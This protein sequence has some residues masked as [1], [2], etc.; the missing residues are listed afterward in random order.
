M[1]RRV[2]DGRTWGLGTDAEVAWVASGT[3][4]GQTSTAAIPPVFEAVNRGAGS[5]SKPC[6]A[7]ADRIMPIRTTG[8]V[9]EPDREDVRRGLRVAGRGFAA[10]VPDSSS[11][12]VRGGGFAAAQRHYRPERELRLYAVIAAILGRWRAAILPGRIGWKAGV[13]GAADRT[14]PGPGL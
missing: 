12:I 4:T 2:R 14:Q 5:G 1:V 13:R 11:Q 10:R 9:S 6:K 8:P 7:K 3:S